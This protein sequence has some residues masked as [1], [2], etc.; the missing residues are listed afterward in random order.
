MKKLMLSILSISMLTSSL[1]AVTYVD[2]KRK[3]ELYARVTYAK[4]RK[5]KKKIAAAIAAA[6]GVLIFFLMA[7]AYGKS[8]EDSSNDGDSFN[9]TPKPTIDDVDK[10]SC[11]DFHS[12]NNDSE[13]KAS[14][15]GKRWY[16]PT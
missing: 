4:G 10:M 5:H 1:D 11:K 16:F 13:G 14:V 8:T 2:L 3:A 12:I 7:R 6:S 9:P 15:K